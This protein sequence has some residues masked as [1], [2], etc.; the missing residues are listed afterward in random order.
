MSKI[1]KK[2]I[3]V[4]SATVKIDGNKVAIKGGS[5]EF[6]HTIPSEVQIKQE[7]KSLVLSIKKDTRRN[8]AL[9][10]L[11][12]A[13]IANMVKGVETGFEKEVKITGLG[14]K[15]QLSGNKLVF[16]LGFSHKIEYEMPDEVSV[17]IDRTGQ[18]LLFKSH[19]KFLLGNVCNA[20]R[21]FKPPEPYKGTGVIRAGDRI[22]RKA[23]KAK[24]V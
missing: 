6:V 7:D 5:F 1:G 3:P 12:R 23:G 22:I 8:R 15:A 21:S 24:T 14:Y 19:D 17:N 16:T 4:S 9:W 2:P 13:L 10:G 18:K 20:V 11:H